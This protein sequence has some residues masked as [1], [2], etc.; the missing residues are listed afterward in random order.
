[1]ENKKLVLLGGGGH[2]KSVLDTLLRSNEFSEIVIC[3]PALPKGSPLFGFRIVGND[4]MLPF[5]MDRGFRFAF[6]TIASIKDTSLRRALVK[7]AETLGFQFPEVID[8]SAVIS[9]Y[10]V[11]GNGSFI[12][13]N[14]V[15]NADAV[16]GCHCILNTGSI[17]EHEC[18]IGDYTH[19]SVGAVLCGNVHVGC[20]SFVGASA[21]VK[22]GISIGERAIIGA[23][24][25]VMK[26]L[27]SAVKAYG[28]PCRVIET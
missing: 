22:Q 19:V 12:G 27:P 21:T 5:L 10:A 15:V 6:I 3:D 11:I 13:K 2:C 9:K 14:V 20:D 16:I 23:G 26:D 1:M 18:F 17:I 24:S 8:P 28:N 4:N 25:V 7:K